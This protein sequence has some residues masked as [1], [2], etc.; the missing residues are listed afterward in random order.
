VPLPD[1][2]KPP[3]GICGSLPY[4]PKLIF[5]SPALILEANHSPLSMSLV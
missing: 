3:N 1:K 2:P 5:A 4:V